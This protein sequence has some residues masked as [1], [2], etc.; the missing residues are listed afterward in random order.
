MNFQTFTKKIDLFIKGSTKESEK[1]FEV[2]T[3]I[4]KE[5]QE[6]NTNVFWKA[7]DKGREQTIVRYLKKKNYHSIH[8]LSF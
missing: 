6:N 1:R 2:L 8:S 3:N 5:V 7:L 4:F